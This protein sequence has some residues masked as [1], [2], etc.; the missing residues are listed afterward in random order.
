MGEKA[1]ELNNRKDGDR[2]QCPICNPREKET[3]PAWKVWLY[4]RVH[5]GRHPK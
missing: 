1:Q 2:A 4:S 5:N 3:V